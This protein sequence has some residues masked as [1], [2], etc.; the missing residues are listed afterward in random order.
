[1]I[2]NDKFTKVTM[3]LMTIQFTNLK[4]LAEVK[5]TNY[6][7]LVR[8]AINDYLKKNKEEK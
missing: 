3:N 5:G 6:S 2:N 4:K 7:T 8:M 1:M